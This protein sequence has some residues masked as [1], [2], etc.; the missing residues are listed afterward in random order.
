MA[1]DDLVISDADRTAA[2]QATT[3]ETATNPTRDAVARALAVARA[4]GVASVPR[5]TDE[6]AEEILK[7]FV[8]GKRPA[9]EVTSPWAKLTGSFMTKELRAIAHQMEKK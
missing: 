7:P 1:E 2:L 4:E 8:D 5:M 9:V 3:D 6:E